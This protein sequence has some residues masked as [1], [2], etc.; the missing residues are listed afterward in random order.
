MKIA[1]VLA[2]PEYNRRRSR[3]LEPG[4]DRYTVNMDSVSK[5]TRSKQTNNY[6]EKQEFVFIFYCYISIIISY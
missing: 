3:L 2:S 6:L 1:L 4:V 5:I